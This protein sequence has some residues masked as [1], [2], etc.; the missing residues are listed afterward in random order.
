MT[1]WRT[2]LFVIIGEVKQHRGNPFC[3]IANMTV[4]KNKLDDT[5]YCYP[6]SHN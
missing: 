2:V 4:D 3:S 6:I 1:E 5:K